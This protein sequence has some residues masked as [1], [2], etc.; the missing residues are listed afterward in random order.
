MVKGGKKSPSVEAAAG[1]TGKGQEPRKSV[2]ISKKRQLE[3]ITSLSSDDDERTAMSKKISWI[4]RHGAKRIGVPVVELE[5]GNWVK[6]ID[7]VQAACMEDAPIEK[8]LDVIEQSNEQKYR[9]DLKETEDGKLIKAIQK[10]DR[11]H[12]AN[13]EEADVAGSQPAAAPSAPAESAAAPSAPAEGAGTAAAATSASP[14]G[15]RVDAPPFFP[16]AASVPSYNPYVL[17]FPPMP[18]PWPVPGA[19]YGYA[20]MPPGAPYGSPP[21]ASARLRGRVKSF[22]ASKGFGFIE[23]T[24][25]RDQY[26]RRH[27]YVHESVLGSFK[28]RDEVTFAV[29]TNKTGMP[30]AANLQSA[31]AGDDRGKGKGK[32]KGGKGKGKGAG[33]GGKKRKHDGSDESDGEPGESANAD[34]EYEDDDE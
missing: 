11:K 26:G 10:Y 32:G 13:F 15:M 14:S 12:T 6:L 22:N 4:L 8:V 1:Q 27:I 17:G 34:I 29:K 9:Y 7:L 3:L 33:K 21:A 24:D 20:P 31:A 16:V 30:Q 23:S 2:P 19:G 25:A 28:V 18:Y 5:D